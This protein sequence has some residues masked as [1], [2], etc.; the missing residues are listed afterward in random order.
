MVD[1]ETGGSLKSVHSFGTDNEAL[2]RVSTPESFMFQM[3]I[4]TCALI[5]MCMHACM[6]ASAQT[7]EN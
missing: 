4:S 7:H 2:G 5:G 6:H 3:S 1:P